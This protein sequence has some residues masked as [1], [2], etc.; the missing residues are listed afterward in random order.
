VTNPLDSPNPYGIRVAAD[1]A[2]VRED[3]KEAFERGSRKASAGLATLRRGRARRPATRRA[4][5]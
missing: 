1:R 5:S 2:P 3:V 4:Q